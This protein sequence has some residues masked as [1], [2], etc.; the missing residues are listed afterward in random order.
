MAE[1]FG[2]DAAALCDEADLIQRQ[3][4]GEHHP[5]KAHLFAGDGPRQVV[6]SHLGGGV[7]RQI[8]G[9]RPHHAQHA[10][11]LDDDGAGSL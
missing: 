9:Q 10:Q 3:L 7:H 5:G 2:F 8:G 6:N 4:P 11:I 1:H